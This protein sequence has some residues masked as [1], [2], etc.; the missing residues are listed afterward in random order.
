VAAAAA[1]WVASALLGHSRP[2]FAPVAAVVALG[3]SYAARLRR[4]GEVVAGVALG[5]AVGDVFV[6]V[7]GTGTW[8]IAV[9]IAFA[10]SL[11]VL[12]EAGP[13]LVTQAGVQ[14]SIVTTLVPPTGEGVDR[15]VDAV[16]GGAVALIAAAVVPASPLRR[17]RR[18]AAELLDDLVDVLLAAANSVQDRDVARAEKALQRARATQRSLDELSDAAQEG[19][20]VLQVSPFRRRHRTGVQDIRAIAEPLDRA[21][22]GVRAVLRQALAVTRNSQPVPTVLVDLVEQLSSACALLA[23][24]VAAERPLNEAVE[25]LEAVARA[26]ATVPRSSLSGDAILAQTRSTVVDLFQVA[27]L[28]PDES[29]ARMPP[30]RGE[31]PHG[32]AQPD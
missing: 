25:A 30:P 21:A 12:L 4:V 23:A 13:M 20:D 29:L 28:D 9:V 17:P 11:A 32:D 15:W 26:S 31:H 1:W 3:V 10:M 7:A 2:F 22:R 27:G 6:R 24:D 5:V 18:L 8:Q 14:A 19:L 16:V